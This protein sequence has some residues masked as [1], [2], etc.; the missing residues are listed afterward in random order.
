[1]ASVYSAG[2][3][4]LWAH[5]GRSGLFPVRP[6]RDLSAFTFLLEHDGWPPVGGHLRSRK[7][8]G[9]ARSALFNLPHGVGAAVLWRAEK[10]TFS[11]C[12]RLGKNVDFGAIFM[13]MSR[14]RD[15]FKCP[16][17]ACYAN[18][19]HCYLEVR[20]NLS[21]STQMYRGLETDPASLFIFHQKPNIKLPFDISTTGFFVFISF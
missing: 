20:A 16:P 19:Q 2:P 5:M 8:S 6:L 9:I 21:T 1:M 3:S 18:W 4:S 13:F 7:R 14:M 17:G 15:I 10:V 11:C 12:R